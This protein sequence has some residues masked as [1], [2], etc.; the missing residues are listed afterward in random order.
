MAVTAS[1]GDAGAGYSMLH[2][3]PETGFPCEVQAMATAMPATANR[4]AP[5]ALPCPSSTSGRIVVCVV[6]APGA[7][8]PTVMPS[9][10]AAVSPARNS[11]T[12]SS[13]TAR[14]DGRHELT[15]DGRW[16]RV[17]WRLPTDAVAARPRCVRR[18]PCW[19]T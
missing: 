3:R 1:P 14:A 9:A 7:T 18:C 12:A 8:A 5:G 6:T 11:R 19:S 4:A 17:A 15:R 13:A 16:V 10:R 2:E